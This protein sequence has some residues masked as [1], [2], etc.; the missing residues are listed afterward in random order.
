MSR[1]CSEARMMESLDKSAEWNIDLFHEQVDFDRLLNK[2]AP[3][4]IATFITT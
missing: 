4:S 2:L 3:V 1:M